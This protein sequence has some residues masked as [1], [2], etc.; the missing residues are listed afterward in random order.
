MKKESDVVRR[1]RLEVI[2]YAVFFAAAWMVSVGTL[3][4]WSSRR[5]H[6]GARESAR[7]SAQAQFDK[8]VLYRRWNASHGGVYVP[9]TE[10]MR[11][12]EYLG[13]IDSRDLET[14]AG[15][16]L[17]LVNP[18]YMTR[19]VHELGFATEGVRGHITSLNPIRPENAADGWERLALE[20]FGRGEEEFSSVEFLDGQEQLRFMRPLMT[21]R[22]CLKC[23]AKQGYVV[24]Q[25][26]GGISVAVP[27]R[28]YQDIMHADI[29]SLA[30]MLGGIWLVGMI[31]IGL[32][33]FHFNGRARE[34]F[35]A[36]KELGRSQEQLAMVLHGSGLGSWDWDVAED[37][38]HFNERWA[39][40]KGYNVDE[41]CPRMASWQELV[42][43]D[44]LDGVRK[45]LTQHLEGKTCGYEAEYRVRTKQGDWM[46]VLDRGRVMERDE[47]G[48]PVRACG[49]HLDITDRKKMEQELY[50]TQKLESV[51]Q[52]AAGIAHEINTPIQF[53]GDNLQFLND[54]FV[55]LLG[56]VGQLEDVIG[57]FKSDTISAEVINRLEQ[58]LVDADLDYLKTEAFLAIQ[59][60]REG[61]DRVTEIV[62]AMKRYAHPGTG[63]KSDICLNESIE[64]TVVIAHNAWKYVA[65]LTM[66]LDKELPSTPCLVG[67][68][69]QVILNLIVNARDA[70][71]E[72]IDQD[73]SEVKGGIRIATTYDEDWVVVSV[74]DSGMGMSEKT[75]SRVF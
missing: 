56:V 42:H 24:G 26:R 3:F 50:Q 9:V 44:E 73:P 71:Q 40:M 5:I 13:S 18:A 54:A 36:K 7:I 64:T 39:G 67:E 57:S 17:T 45:L 32:A 63:V 51:G 52:L 41:I 14:T 16:M 11:P 66:D 21:E 22:G 43:P 33:A 72:R 69:N 2:K 27:M 62:G 59:Q 47:E 31:V 23:H 10:H 65:D 4:V 61:T 15:T 46:W 34:R 38:I 37:R 70:I 28:P 49:T 30:G 20:R 12:N 1:Y 48:V 58:S 6:D 19:Q 35:R 53:V 29:K 55:D 74:E 68:I 75:K 25:V 8:D 60:S